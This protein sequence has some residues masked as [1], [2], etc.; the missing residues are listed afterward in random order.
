MRNKIIDRAKEHVGRLLEQQL[1]RIERIKTGEKVIDYL[2][3]QPII[4]GIIGGDGIGPYIA[5]EAQRVL[6]V[7]LANELS[8]GK[9]EFRII[10]G[11]TIEKRAEVNKPI[12]E[13]ILEE[14]KQCH[15]TLKGPTTTP[16]KGDPWPNIESANIALR[17]ELDLYANVRPVRVPKDGIDWTFFR[18]NTEGAYALGS[19]GIDVTDD[20][21]VDFTVTSTQ[22]SKR[23]IRLAFEYARRNNINKLT[24]V[25]KANV[26]KTTDGKFLKI[27]QE[28]AKD[29]PEVE[30]DDWYIDIMTAKL[31][32]PKRRKQF[33][34]L[35][36]PNLYGDILTDEAAELQGGVGTAGSAN[37]GDKYSMFEAIHG[38]APRMVEEGRAKYA[39]PCSM[40]RAGAMLMNHIGFEDRGRKLGMALDITSQFEKKLVNTGRDTGATGREFCDYLLDTINDSNLK[41]KWKLYQ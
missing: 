2:Q 9:I 24:I 41:E 36:L 19:N 21:A 1:D 20:L 6:E 15:V 14:I 37:I 10:E 13:D 34:V 16:R 25:T 38:S 40:I 3:I 5:N 27:G 29:Y 28:I 30:V 26:V 12:P 33:K 8:S 7:L 31:I 35:V 4:V 32:D 22:G 39:D 23:I 17:K 18:E 11:L